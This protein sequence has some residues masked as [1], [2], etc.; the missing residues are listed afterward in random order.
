VGSVGRERIFKFK[1]GVSCLDFVNTLAW[2]LT[3]RPVEYL[4]SYEDL[5]AW[6]RQAGLLTPDEAEA[7]SGWAATAPEEAGDTLTR[8]VALREAIHRVFS[9]AITGKPQANRSS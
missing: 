1:G 8:A 2:R 9:A 3:D 4:G 5:L 7:L 6:G